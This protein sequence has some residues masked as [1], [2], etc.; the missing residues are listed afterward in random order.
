MNLFENNTINIYGERGKSWLAQLPE[1]ITHLAKSWHLSSLTPV[2]NMSYNYVLSGFQDKQPIILKLS[3]DKTGLQREAK[4]L[5]A[6][7][8]A[9][10]VKVF[11]QQDDALL[12]ERASPGI[13][14]KRFFPKQDIQAIKITSDVIKKLHQAPL[15]SRNIFLT[16]YDWLNTLDKEWSIP[17]DYLHKARLLRNQLLATTSKMVLLHGD[18]HHDNILQHGDEWK[19]IDPKGVMGDPVYEVAAFIRNP[20]PELLEELDGVNLIHQRIDLFARHLDVD[21][22]RIRDWCYVQAVL[23]WIWTLEDR[24]DAT[25][26]AALVGILD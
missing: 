9:G 12:I 8:S 14:L 18:L 17:T 4:A 21:K 6:F 13:S 11:A 22:Q 7:V 23:A 5:A 1:Q 16:I 2:S 24:G 15:S 26:F 3:L 10:A 20:I 19:V 25:Y